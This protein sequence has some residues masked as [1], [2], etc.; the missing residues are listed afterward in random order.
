[1]QLLSHDE[2]TNRLAILGNL[3]A[4]KLKTMPSGGEH[5]L[6]WASSVKLSYSLAFPKEPEKR[7]ATIAALEHALEEGVLDA[8]IG[9][10]R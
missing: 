4:E 1:G 5:L 10:A 7:E 9:L 2:E 8:G 3:W 6:V